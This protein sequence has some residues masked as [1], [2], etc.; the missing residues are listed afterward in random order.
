MRATRV[1]SHAGGV[2]GVGGAQWVVHGTEKDTSLWNR[3][4][5]HVSCVL[6]SCH[7]G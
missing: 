3:H 6:V 2:G 1:M 4:T 7:V 5:S